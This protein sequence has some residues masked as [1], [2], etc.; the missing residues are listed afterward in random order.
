MALYAS[1]FWNLAIE[2]SAIDGTEKEELGVV[3]VNGI[4]SNGVVPVGSDVLLLAT[5]SCSAV[6][7]KFSPIGCTTIVGPLWGATSVFSSRKIP[8]STV[9]I[10]ALKMSIC[11]MGS[12]KDLCS[13]KASRRKG[14][15]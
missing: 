9:P 7:A 8:I 3:L 6:S 11:L 13:S 15:W 12:P 2:I 14:T 10:G 5:L 1:K 4:D